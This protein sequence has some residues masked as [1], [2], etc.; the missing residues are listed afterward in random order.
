MILKVG[1]QSLNA[2]FSGPKSQN[3]KVHAHTPCGRLNVINIPV[4]FEAALNLWWDETPIIYMKYNDKKY[5]LCGTQHSYVLPSS[6]VPMGSC[7]SCDFTDIWIGDVTEKHVTTNSVQ[8][9]FILYR[10]DAWD[11]LVQKREFLLNITNSPQ[12]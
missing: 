6:G 11:I 2:I 4:L 3:E 7:V 10:D 9:K 5:I 12:Y 8:I 1:L